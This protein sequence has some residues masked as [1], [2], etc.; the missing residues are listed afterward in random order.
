[1]KQLLLNA[2]C[3]EYKW[4]YLWWTGIL[5]IFQVLQGYT[6]ST[7]SSLS[8]CRY[9]I[10]DLW[11]VYGVFQQSVEI[12]RSWPWQR[13][14]YCHLIGCSLLFFIHVINDQISS[15]WIVYQYI[16]T[17]INISWYNILLWVI[18]YCS[19]LHG[20]QFTN[21]AVLFLFHC[22]DKAYAIWL[23]FPSD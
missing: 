19:D 21:N 9:H 3:T 6:T 12:R 22:L 5:L 16:N 14:H 18:I 1:M 15:I 23:H 4:L 2:T 20:K 10:H 17:D 7:E 8:W 13:Q 11:L